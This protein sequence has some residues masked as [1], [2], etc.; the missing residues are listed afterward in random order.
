MNL[1]QC[2]RALGEPDKARRCFELLLTDPEFKD[3]A[4]TLLAMT[5]SGASGTG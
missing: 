4:A 5:S 1:G 2:Y 3:Q